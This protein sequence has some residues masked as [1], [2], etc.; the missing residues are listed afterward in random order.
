MRQVEE[1]ID[2]G[3]EKEQTSPNVTLLKVQVHIDALRK[4]NCGD[5]VTPTAGKH[6]HFSHVSP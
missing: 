2:R 5:N 6:I 4:Q 1:W 3:R